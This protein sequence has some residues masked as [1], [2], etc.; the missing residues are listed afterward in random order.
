[1]TEMTQ[2]LQNQPRLPLIMVGI[3]S[4][5]LS[6]C[7]NA[8]PTSYRIPKEERVVAMAPAATPAVSA[9]A[10][11]EVL[12]GMEAAAQKAGE[13]NYTAPEGWEDLPASGIRKANLKVTTDTGSAEI[14][15][16]TF[17]GDVG[18]RLANINRWRGQIGLEE[19]TPEDLPADTEG[20]DISNHR[21]LYVRLEGGEQSILGALLPFHGNTW[22]VKMIG[23]TPTVL[24]NE[25]AM[26][27]FLDSIELEDHAH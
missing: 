8:Q 6:G 19:A 17:P 12:P 26:K 3:A 15:I 13:I 24:A 7:D 16:L 22:F 5:C 10:K 21:G 23:D 2:R 18:G 27:Q 25:A 20:Y 1:M 9:P 11:M 4:L 14:T